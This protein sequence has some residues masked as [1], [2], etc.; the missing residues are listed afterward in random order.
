MMD[1]VGCTDCEK[2]TEG[3]DPALCEHCG[4]ANVVPIDMST[5]SPRLKEHE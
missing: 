1:F 5:G 2:I 3:D 4:S